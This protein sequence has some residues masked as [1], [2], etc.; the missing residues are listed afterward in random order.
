MFSFKSFQLQSHK[1]FRCLIFTVFCVFLTNCAVSTR[2]Q[3]ED[4]DG[5][6]SESF[7]KSIKKNRTLK[8]VVVNIIFPVTKYNSFWYQLYI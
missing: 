8:D 4:N 6:L 1:A 7:F 3:Y 2:T 5:Y